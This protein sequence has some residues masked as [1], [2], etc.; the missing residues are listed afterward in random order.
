M[1]NSY[2]YDLYLKE[3]LTESEIA[4]LVKLD[5]KDQAY[6]TDRGF[7][8]QHMGGQAFAKDE[9]VMGWLFGAH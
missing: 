6:F 2:L 8:D 7:T 1:L 5:V 4:Q 9:S 3:N